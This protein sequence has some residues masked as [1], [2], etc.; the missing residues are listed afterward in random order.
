MHI[1]YPHHYQ[2]LPLLIVGPDPISIN[3]TCNTSNVMAD[4]DEH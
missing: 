3:W 2:M 1:Q 4:N